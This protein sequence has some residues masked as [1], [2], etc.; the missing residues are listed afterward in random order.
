MAINN[1][2]LV[3]FCFF[4]AFPGFTVC[5]DAIDLPQKEESGLIYS[6][7]YHLLM[8]IMTLVTYK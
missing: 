2:I 8:T 5:N 4:W 1:A 6:H 3:L 7:I